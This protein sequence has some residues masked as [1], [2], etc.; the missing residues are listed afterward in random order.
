MSLGL[1]GLANTCYQD[2]IY[3]QTKV[4]TQNS[5]V[6]FN[7]FIS[8][9]RTENTDSLQSTT[10]TSASNVETYTE[11]L[12]SK[13]GKVTIKS[14]GKDQASLDRMGKCMGG[15]DVVIAPNILEEMANN[16]EKAIYYEKKIDD[17][18]DAVPSLNVSFASKGLIH[19]PGGVVIHEDGSVTY[20][21]GCSDSP[22]RVAEVNKI[23]KAKQ[24]KRIKQRKELL[25]RSQEA[26]ER[27]RQIIEQNNQ[28]LILT[29][30][31]K[32]NTLN[33]DKTLDT[34]VSSYVIGAVSAYENMVDVYSESIIKNT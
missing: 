11:Y 19:E 8:A 21:G 9:K 16:P 26:A 13:Y 6:D 1:S 7:G 24:E 2:Y 29:K 28:K 23:N 31:I 20:I 12:R 27:Q 14:V 34:N 3:Q 22:E 4:T 25:E 33:F 30:A 5:N 10:E 18:F 32:D 17:F 15:N